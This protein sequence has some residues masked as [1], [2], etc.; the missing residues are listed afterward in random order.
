MS[1]SNSLVQRM[2]AFAAWMSALQGGAQKR[3]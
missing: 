1:L 3:H 2:I